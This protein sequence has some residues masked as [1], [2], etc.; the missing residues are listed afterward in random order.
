MPTTLRMLAPRIPGVRIVE[1]GGL[2][3]VSFLER[4]LMAWGLRYL[5][6]AS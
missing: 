1:L 6:E 3:D 5:G 4:S 2:V